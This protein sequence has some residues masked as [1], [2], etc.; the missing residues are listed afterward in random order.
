[1]LRPV[2]LLAAALWSGAASA[3][4]PP[5]SPAPDYRQDGAWLCRPGR[6]DICDAPLD[7][8]ATERGRRVVRRFAE[9]PNPPI[10]CFYVYPTVS[11]DPGPFSDLTPGPEEARTTVGQAARFASRCR[12]FAPVY[13]QATLAGLRARMRGGP[14]EP[15]PSYDDVRAAWRDYLRRDN[16]GR[17]VVLIGHSQGSIHLAR[18]LRE[19]IAPAPAQRRLLVSAILAGHPS[20][21]TR[22]AGLPP[23]DS[24]L[25]VPTC[26]SANDTGCAIAFV[27]YA[28]GDLGL[29]LF[30]LSSRLGHAPVCVNPAALAG[31]RGRLTGYVRRPET[32]PATDPPYVEASFEARCVVVGLAA[33]LRVR[34]SDAPG[35][36]AL[37]NLTPQTGGLPGW[38]LHPL[39]LTLPQ[40]TLL[41]VVERQGRAW[42]AA[43]R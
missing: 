17:G 1:M 25:A 4:P 34:A 31:G 37:Q 15:G 33:S 36:T 5:A 30:G 3:Q 26:R 23:A 39:D 40:G 29:Q 11:L 7:V 42:T 13:R 38:G 32:A 9:A 20:L 22:G 27:S 35:E 2:L 41:D 16:R 18:L 21:T 10:D 43:R 28:A 12:L 24:D 14:D 6:T 8:L 19:E